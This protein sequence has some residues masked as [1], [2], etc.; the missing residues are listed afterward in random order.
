VQIST[1]NYRKI[2][3][4]SLI[5][6]LFWIPISNTQIKAESNSSG[7]LPSP[8][9]NLLAT[10][11]D[12]YITLT[13]DPP[14][15]E[16]NSNIIKYYIYRETGLDKLTPGSTKIKIA[17]ATTTNYTDKE[18]TNCRE[19]YYQVSG[20]NS[21]GEGEKSNEASA[22]PFQ[23]Y[24]T[25]IPWVWIT[26]KD[27][28][29]FLSWEKPCDYCGPPIIKYNIYRA[30]TSDSTKTIIGETTSTSFVDTNVTNGEKYYYQISAVNQFGEGEKSDEVTHLAGPAPG[31]IDD[32]IAVPKNNEIF[33]SWSPPEDNGF[34]ITKYYIY[35]ETLLEKLTPCTTKVKIAEA[36]T[37][38]YTDT[39]LKNGEIYFYQVTAIN[40]F[41]EGEKS[42]E[43]SATPG[44]LL[45]KEWIFQKH[46]QYN[47]DNN[48]ETIEG[49]GFLKGKII[50]SGGNLS[51]EG[52]IILN[53]P[54]PVNI[55][56]VYLITTNG[57]N[58]E[59]T[60][61][62]IEIRNFHYSQQNS[63]TFSFSGQII[64]V[65]QPINNGHFEIS[66]Q[67][68][69]DAIKYEFFLNTNSQ[70]NNHYLP[71]TE[72]QPPIPI[73]SFHPKNPVKGTKVKFDGAKSF[74]F[75]GEIVSF[76][77][78]IASS[79]FYGTTT[80]FTFDENGEYQIILT[81]TDEN[82]TTSSTS[83]IIKVEPFSFVLIT[84]LHIGWGIPDYN[85]EGY[86][87]QEEGQDYYMTE[88]LKMVVDWINGNYERE[89]IKFVVVDG[90]ISDTAEYSEFLKAREILNQLK[91]PYIPLIGNHDIWPNTQKL[92]T[93]PDGLGGRWNTIKEKRKEGEPLGDEYFEKI[94]WQDNATNT[95]RIKALFDNFER[96]EEIPQYQGPPYFQNY[97][98]NFGGTTFIALDF[99]DRNYEG[100]IPMGCSTVRIWDET[101]SWLEKILKEKEG[102]KTV[103]F[104]HQPFGI[105][106]GKNF[107]EIVKIINKYC[108]SEE[109]GC[110]IYNFAGH[111]HRKSIF[112][113]SY[114][115]SPFKVPADEVIET[116]ALLQSPSS[117]GPF[118]ISS[119]N[120]LRIVQITGNNST[121]IEYNIFASGFPKPINPFI[122]T[123]KEN[124]AV[125]ESITFTA[126]TKNLDPK[127]I[128]EYIWKFDEN[129][130][131]SCKRGEN[132][133]RVN[134]TGPHNIKKAEC[135][136]TKWVCTYGG[137]FPFDVENECKVVYNA[138]GIYKIS[139]KVISKDNPNYSEEI[140][141]NLKIGERK[142]RW[143]IILPISNLFPLLN[144]QG[145]IVLTEEENAQNTEEFVLLK[146]ELASPSVPIGG[147][148]VHF[149]KAIKDIDLSG[150]VAD[151]DSQ[152]GKSILY[153]EN[154][155]KEVER[156]KILLISKK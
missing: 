115:P 72:N 91:I 31:E 37:T 116:E 50:L 141:W 38:S 20:V 2:V 49:T 99:N 107:A 11:S 136:M 12:G 43:V 135:R 76:E 64:N 146:K 147:F 68:N 35:R 133:C 103:I 7:D 39:Q 131:I 60:K 138:M 152:K 24:P 22:T 3:I 87:D 42:N 97:S 21:L 58:K 63:S 148:N 140:S 44:I 17:E 110:K 128:S 105:L 150:L 55:P 15:N 144:G 95:S 4:F 25:K 104:V 59:L 36:T 123:N 62:L 10:P 100:L 122:T 114:L 47:L 79:T 45:Q 118:T 52:E 142:P 111:T 70:I 6:V 40:P 108:N 54:L 19:Y 134:I 29:I 139:L 28:Q 8:P 41:G 96:Q 57:P 13:W 5:L 56:E 65:V 86:N 30:T 98:F 14:L 130:S 73:I 151:I 77:W 137:C 46:F 94:F 113:L 82:G 121:E 117:F 153:M 34:P 84:D 83:T 154:W 126:H 16:E 67:V 71:L 125:D 132:E 127:D 149:E 80:E 145:N 89:N 81:V 66:A 124:P 109:L 27:G 9:Q 69:Y 102:E 74:D 26:S 32:L 18:V 88:R 33:L 112:R 119:G 129:Y 156:S 120:F 106:Y 48:Y 1:I 101:L 90:D 23:K 53:G 61:Q 93:D 85:G 92:T 75:D 155:P 78:Q 143:K 51:A